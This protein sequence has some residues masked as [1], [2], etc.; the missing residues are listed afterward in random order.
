MSCPHNYVIAIITK[1]PLILII[2][3]QSFLIENVTIANCPISIPLAT[4]IRFK[5]KAIVSLTSNFKILQ[6]SRHLS[7]PKAYLNVKKNRLLFLQKVP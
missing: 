4:I 6:R 1:I 2:R 3:S 7:F 5:L